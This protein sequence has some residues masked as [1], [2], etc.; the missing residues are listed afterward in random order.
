MSQSEVRPLTRVAFLIDNYQ[1]TKHGC[2][3]WKTL[4]AGHV[5]TKRACKLLDKMSFECGLARKNATGEDLRLL[6]K[7]IASRLRST[8]GAL[9]LMAYGG[10][11][12]MYNGRLY[13]IPTDHASDLPEPGQWFL[14]AVLL[15]LLSSACMAFGWH[16]LLNLTN[17]VGIVL[18]IGSLGWIALARWFLNMTWS[19]LTSH[20]LSNAV[21]LD[22]IEAELANMHETHGASHAILL[23]LLDCCRD[24]GH[25]SLWHRFLLRFAPDKP[26][27]IRISHKNS[28]PNF[29]KVFACEEGRAAI[30]WPHGFLTEAF[31]AA[32]GNL[33]CG[34]TLDELL[35][36]L[37][38]NIRTLCSPGLQKVCI[39][40]T[41]YRLAKQIVFWDQHA[42]AAFDVG[43]TLLTMRK[44]HLSTL[45]PPEWQLFHKH[46]CGS[47][48]ERKQILALPSLSDDL[49][50]MLL[51]R[52]LAEKRSGRGLL[53][54]SLNHARFCPVIINPPLK[55]L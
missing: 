7:Q 22:Q 1:Y 19:I 42:D 20:P 54:E 10:H 50:A 45:K 21:C 24:F 12:M 32:L 16:G 55:C 44:G 49:R 8:H 39:Y 5:M 3:F 43:P 28:R 6:P 29:F 27:A 31:V 38:E 40:S 4:P 37:D 23:W 36:L 11:A 35:T 51:L 30:G 53:R 33:R 41:S 2:N 46:R 15:M 9:A 52:I 17:E 48:K 13:F 47:P 34:G 14:A 25:L 26:V 18:M